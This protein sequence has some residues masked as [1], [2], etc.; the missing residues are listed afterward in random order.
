MLLWYV[1]ARTCKCALLKSREGALHICS[2]LS[3]LQYPHLKQFIGVATKHS[4][5]GHLIFTGQRIGICVASGF[6]H[7]VND[8]RMTEQDALRMVLRHARCNTCMRWQA[9][10]PSLCTHSTT[11]DEYRKTKIVLLTVESL[12]C[13]S[14]VIKPPRRNYVNLKVR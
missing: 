3:Y 10:G 14:S 7:S 8:I 12:H 13:S 11:Y 5:Q 9:W 1:L 4:L 2:F 6:P